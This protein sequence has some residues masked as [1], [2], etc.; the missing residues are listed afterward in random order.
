MESSSILAFCT[1]CV[2]NAVDVCQVKGNLLAHQH[3]DVA[4]GCMPAI[5]PAKHSMAYNWPRDEVSQG[6][7][8]PLR[9]KSSHPKH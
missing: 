2:H 4:N 8:T 3:L 5:D 7:L 9:Q 1:P 6:S